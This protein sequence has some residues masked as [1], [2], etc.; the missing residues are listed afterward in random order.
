[1]TYTWKEFNINDALAGMLVGIPTT[2]PASGQTV[3][4]NIDDISKV[5]GNLV[6]AEKYKEY[7]VV[8]NGKTAYI[9]NDGTV[10]ASTPSDAYAVGTQFYLASATIVE[11]VGNA[12]TR[13][14]TQETGYGQTVE[15]TSLE[16]RD[17]FAIQIL[18][19]MLVHAGNPETFDDANIM[20]YTRAS[21]RWAQGMLNSAANA[22]HGESETQT[23]GG[24][25]INS[26]DLQSNVEKLLYNIGEYMKNGMAVKGS[27]ELGASPVRTEV[28]GL[29]SMN[30]AYTIPAIIDSQD[31]PITINIQA[32]VFKQ[33]Y[34][35]F[36]VLTYMA[37]SDIS[38][39]LTL[40]TNDGARNVGHIIPKGSVVVLMPLDDAVTDITAINSKSI[41]G[42]GGNDPNTYSIS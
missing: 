33:K 7:K 19:A 10:Y 31:N 5:A 25:A 29:E 41:R 39:Y 8:I 18:S 35:R 22:R 1:M 26:N 13:T 30:N 3:N 17:S 21:Y 9:N 37:Y 11:T 6:K 12:F 38:V 4:E 36:E 34:I 20:M 14:S 15:I 2:A 24:V 28:S 42:K 23:P 27:V 40:T 32:T 16:A